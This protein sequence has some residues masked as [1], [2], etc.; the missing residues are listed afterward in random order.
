MMLLAVPFI[1]QGGVDPTAF[2]AALAIS[3]TVVD[4]CPFSTAGALVI[5]NSRVD[6]RDHLYRGL[7]LWGG[8]M[9][10]TAPLLTWLVIIL[11]MQ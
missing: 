1:G 8:L 2:V 9:I 4:S 3:A 7:L 10:L 11:P 6:E 5:A